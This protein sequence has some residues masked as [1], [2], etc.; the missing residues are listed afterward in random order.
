MTARSAGLQ[1]QAEARRNDAAASRSD[2]DRE[3]ERADEIDP[4]S[5]TSDTP[6]GD[7]G[8]RQVR[9]RTPNAE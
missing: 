5:A 9:A 8:A 2:L 1:H 7:G 4:D 3:F 6:R